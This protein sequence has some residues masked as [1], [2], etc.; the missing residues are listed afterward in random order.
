[1]ADSMIRNVI[2]KMKA[3]VSVKQNDI[4]IPSEQ[5]RS[6]LPLL[7]VW[8]YEDNDEDVKIKSKYIYDKLL[9][10]NKDKPSDELTSILTNLGATKWNENKLNRVYRYFRLKGEADKALNYHNLLNK[11]IDE[12]KR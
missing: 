6:I 5:Y 1:M 4:F 9:T 10:L 11:E 2:E 7:D 3:E 12:L 8:G